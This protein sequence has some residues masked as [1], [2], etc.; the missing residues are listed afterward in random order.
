MSE[1]VFAG[2]RVGVEGVSPDPTKL[3]AIVNWPTPADAS[4]LEGFLGLTSYFRD[5][6]KGYAQLEAPQRIMKGFKLEK[7]WDQSHT[8]TFLALKARNRW[9]QRRVCGRA[10]TRNNNNITSTSEEKY[11]P[12][13][14]EFAALKFAFDKF[15]DI[16]YGYP[17]KV[18]TDCQALRD[19]P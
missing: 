1:A 19:V 18:R 2:A 9:M 12:F 4:H 15:S 16:V 6:T 10:G 7:I 17:V 3:T 5:L 11:K 8:K 14:L 13:L